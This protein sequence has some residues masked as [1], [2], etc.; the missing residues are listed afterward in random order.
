MIDVVALG[1]DPA[2]V[3]ELDHRTL[4][5]PTLKLRSARQAGRDGALFCVDLRVRRPNAGA[6]LCDT[7]LHSL[8]HFLLEGLQRELPGNFVGV[9]LMGCQTGFYLTFLDEGRAQRLCAALEAVLTGV[10]AATA[11]PYADIAQCGHYRNHSV[12]QAQA[13][14]REILAARAHW[15]EAA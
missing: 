13:V 1:W 7:A 10:A 11:V 3:G 5:A 15:L 4:K 8:E 9:G 14:A 6:F 2:T 12:E